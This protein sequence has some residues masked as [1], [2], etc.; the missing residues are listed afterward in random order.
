MVALIA[1]RKAG[2]ALLSIIAILMVPMVMLG[3]LYVQTAYEDIRML[4]RE[5]AGSQISQLV[6]PVMLSRDQTVADDTLMKIREIE[7]TVG[8]SGAQGFAAH[9]KGNNTK[10]QVNSTT[11]HSHEHNVSSYL[12]EVSGQTGLI[13]DEDAEIH[14]LVRALLS[15]LP[16]LLI[17]FE[18]LLQSETDDTPIQE[19]DFKRLAQ[20]HEHIGR[21]SGYFELLESSITS[22]EIYSKQNE[23]FVELTAAVAHMENGFQN[24][25]A[26]NAKGISN[27]AALTSAT[28]ESTR[29]AGKN[30]FRLSDS[31]HI[32]AFKLLDQRLLE[33]RKSLAWKLGAMLLLGVG[34]AVAALVLT[35]KMVRKTLVKLDEVESAHLE[36]Q[37]I[38]DDVATLNVE[39][40]GKISE[41]RTAHDEIVRK[42]K[43]EQLGQLTA[44]IAHELR[45]PLGSLRTSA[46]LIQRKIEGKNVDIVPQLDRINNGITRCD[47]II[48][49]LLDYS[50]TRKIVPTETNLD[51]WLEKVVTDELAKLPASVQLECTLGLE[52]LVVPIDA[53]RLQRAVINL[54][55][56]ANEAM[57]N[58]NDTIATSQKIWIS[59]QRV[60]EYV[61]IRVTDNGP[62][63]SAENLERI[64]EPL[65]TTKNFGTGL[66]IPAIEQIA[67]QH[68]GYLKIASIEGQGAT[69]EM[70][71]P[72]QRNAEDDKA[73]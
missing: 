43:L 5:Y 29:A 44:T 33:R 9:V 3:S 27:A 50:R 6:Y 66:G 31:F 55:S 59:T 21:T 37:R 51:E 14:Y 13:L 65:F 19:N 36:T 24:R 47:N 18:N 54:I 12:R 53:T 2:R 57:I 8:L 16:L 67:M 58:K 64:R 10:G 61:S 42:G 70:F 71:L 60:D 25:L 52:D 11:N 69:F 49:Q 26:S 20:L 68:N 72:I 32:A 15:D 30:L 22:A 38:S 40:A 1:S 34:A 63:I 28:L 35:A 56:N 39:L 41:L 23:A 46:F 48:T 7:A 45:N 4:D 62:G 73:A 17:N